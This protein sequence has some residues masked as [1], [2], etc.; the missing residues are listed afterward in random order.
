VDGGVITILNSGGVGNIITVYA[1]ATDACANLSDM[2]ML[3]ID[4]VNPSNRS[5]NEGVGNGE[6][7][8]TPGHD[9]NG[10]NDDPGQTPGNPGAKGGKKNR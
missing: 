8:N 6:D 9:N 7:G 1:S 5:G 4:V 3:I 10:G 2:E